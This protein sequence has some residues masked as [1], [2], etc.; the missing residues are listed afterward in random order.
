M[1][2][3]IKQDSHLMLEHDKLLCKNMVR[4]HRHTLHIP[5]QGA[6]EHPL[7]SQHQRHH[8]HNPLPLMI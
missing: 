6:V 1:C 7:R 3:S 8:L 5:D 2:F 4:S